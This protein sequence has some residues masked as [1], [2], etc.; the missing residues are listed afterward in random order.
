MCAMGMIEEK[1]GFWGG[2]VTERVVSV[3]LLSLRSEWRQKIPITSGKQ[4]EGV[5]PGL[6]SLYTAQK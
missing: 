3:R 1:S 2:K 6:I 4:R 5:M